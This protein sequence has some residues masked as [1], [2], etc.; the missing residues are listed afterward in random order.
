MAATLRALDADIARLCKAGHAGGYETEAQPW[1]ASTHK[2]AELLATMTRPAVEEDN[3]FLVVIAVEL[4]L[5][6]LEV[7]D[8]DL[9]KVALEKRDTGPVGIA[10]EIK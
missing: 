4:G 10:I 9:F 2:A 1:P 8:N 7:R 3:G 6:A 5:D